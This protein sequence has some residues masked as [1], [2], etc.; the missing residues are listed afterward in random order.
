MNV[1]PRR[2]A[3]GGTSYF[4]LYMPILEILGLCVVYI[5]CFRVADDSQNFLSLGASAGANLAAAVVLKLRDMDNPIR[6]S[7]QVLFVPCLQAFDFNTPSYQE[8]VN[9]GFLP[10]YW[11]I[12]FWL[13]YAHGPDGHRRAYEYVE[14]QHTSADAKISDI[15]AHVDHN[16]IARRLITPSYV[17]NKVDHGNV[18]LW[19]EIEPLFMNPYFAPLMVRNFSELP[20][21]YITTAQWDVLRDDG[22]MYAKH[23]AAAGV[24]VEHRYYEDGFHALTSQFDHFT[25]SRRVLAELIQ[26]LSTHL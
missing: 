4:S 15:A 10:R 21:T 2:I 25:L 19:K 12:N 18:T 16:L 5:I 7:I 1:D 17:P 24:T 3:I 26:Y 13:W 23:L 22:V 11:M 9:N 20:D 8:S 6:P 14:N